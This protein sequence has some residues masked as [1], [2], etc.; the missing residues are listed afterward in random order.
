MFNLGN[1]IKDG[2]YYD[3]ED[4][5]YMNTHFLFSTEKKALQIKLF[6]DDFETGN[7]LLSQKGIH[8]L[9]G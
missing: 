5:L 2:I 6:Y 3:L 4:G 9:G 8:K 7:P 1:N